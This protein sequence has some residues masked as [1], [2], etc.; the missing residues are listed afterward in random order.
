MVT[1]QQVFDRYFSWLHGASEWSH[2]IEKAFPQ[3]SF[4]VDHAILYQAKSYWND[5][6]RFKSF[7]LAYS[8]LR[9]D[10]LKKTAFTL[11][12]MGAF[13]LFA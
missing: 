11:Y 4:G 6:D 1:D 5:I 2:E 7:H 12:W 13:A 8:S 9:A 3:F 10:A